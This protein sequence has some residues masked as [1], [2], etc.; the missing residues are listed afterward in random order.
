MSEAEKIFKMEF[1]QGP[2]IRI[3]IV[4]DLETLAA[5]MA[6]KTKRDNGD[7]LIETTPCQ[8]DGPPDLSTFGFDISMKPVGP[9][10]RTVERRSDPGPGF[11][12]GSHVS[13]A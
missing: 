3:T 7:V 12:P 10:Q 6:V 5:T 13:G 1:E 11:P 9:T 4:Y 8:M 2:D